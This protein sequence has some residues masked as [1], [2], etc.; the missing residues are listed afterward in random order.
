M[1][2]T[3]MEVPPLGHPTT[4]SGFW[5]IGASVRPRCHKWKRISSISSLTAGTRFRGMTTLATL[6]ALRHPSSKYWM[7]GPASLEVD[8]CRS[9]D[10][11]KL[12]LYLFEDVVA[13]QEKG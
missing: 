6:L 5:S 12:P 10:I 7:S 11:G 9:N 1:L 4:K 8:S 13:Q 2:H 3:A